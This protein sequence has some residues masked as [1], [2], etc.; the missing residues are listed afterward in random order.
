ME[1]DKKDTFADYLHTLIVQFFFLPFPYFNNTKESFM[2]KKLFF[3][4]SLMISLPLT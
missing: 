3:M 4:T 2:L 1:C